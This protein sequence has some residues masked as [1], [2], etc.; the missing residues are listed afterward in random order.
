MKKLS[1]LLIIFL[2]S[3]SLFAANRIVSLSPAGTEILYAVGAGDKIVARTD[4]CNY[5]EEAS[6]VPSVGG[7]DGKT[8]SVEAIVSYNPDFVYGSKGMHDFLEEPLSEFGIKL[9]LSAADSVSSVLDEITYIGKETNC[10][11]NAK[12]VRSDIE[13]GLKKLSKVSKKSV[14]W[15]I[16]NAPYMTIGSSSFINEIITLAGGENL[17]GDM[18]DGYP[19]VSEEEI[20]TRN[21]DI[22]IVPSDNWVSAEDVAAR[23]GWDSINAVKNGKI[24]IVNG[25]IFSRPGPRILDACVELNKI[26]K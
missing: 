19:M 9:Y 4:F 15:E 24:I 6:K 11:K 10:T 22:I 16:W 2:V 23:A 3:F 18:T 7:F 25:D 8:L 12:K 5:P 21:P 20:I 13:K 17:F 14:Y 1:L 26:L